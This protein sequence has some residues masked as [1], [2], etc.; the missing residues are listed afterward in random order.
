MSLKLSAVAERNATGLCSD[1]TQQS[2]LT[3]GAAVMTPASFGVWSIFMSLGKDAALIAITTITIFT[4]RPLH[5]LI[6]YTG[7]DSAIIRCRNGILKDYQAC[8]VEQDRENDRQGE[9]EWI[10]NISSSR[11]LVLS[12][13]RVF[14]IVRKGADAVR[15]QV[16]TR[17]SGIEL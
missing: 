2:K 9:R 1:V 5:R 12:M 4:L 7:A 14:D 17:I 6:R 13:E 16:R 10:I 8:E 3:A 11:R 15:G